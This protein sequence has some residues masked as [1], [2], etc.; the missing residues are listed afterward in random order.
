MRKI[1]LA[2]S[3]IAALAIAAP[4]WAQYRTQGYQYPN[5]GSGYQ[6]QGY[7]GDNFDARLERLEARLRAGVDRG[8]IGRDAGWRLS[9][10]IDALEDLYNRYRR[11]GLSDWER[12]D[13]Q[14]R[15]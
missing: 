9:G 5:Q 6:N 1:F 3:A 2:T 10:D 4:G 15:L 13:L 14:Q 11:D 8:A 12:E 7:R